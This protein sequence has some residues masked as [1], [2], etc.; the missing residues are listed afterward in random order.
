MKGWQQMRE[1]LQ[2]CGRNLPRMVIKAAYAEMAIE[3]KES[4]RRTPVEFGTA[5]ASHVLRKPFQGSG[6]WVIVIEVG[7]GGAE[8]YII[9]LHENLD[10][11]HPNGGQAKFLESTL[12]E[13][14]PY[15][16]QRIANR[17]RANFDEILS[18]GIE[19]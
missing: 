16:N 17:V 7:A 2:R 8:G 15:M 5:R 10:A 9:P 4:M 14:A 1:N 18:N 6:F 13:S 19:V 12:H 11:D 3:M